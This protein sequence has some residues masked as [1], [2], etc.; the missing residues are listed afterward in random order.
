MA[1]VKRQTTWRNKNRREQLHRNQTLEAYTF[2]LCLES[3]VADE[4]VAAKQGD[5]EE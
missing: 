1:P 2:S 5:S 3:N 4:F